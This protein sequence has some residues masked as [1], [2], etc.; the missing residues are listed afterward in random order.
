MPPRRH[1]HPWAQLHVTPGLRKKVLASKNVRIWFKIQ[2]LVK[3]TL[4]LGFLLIS[5]G[6]GVSNTPLFSAAV[7]TAEV[8]AGGLASRH[9]WGEGQDSR[10]LV[11]GSAKPG[12]A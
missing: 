8:A 6:F 11:S 5:A 9:P 3:L 4:R 1:S 10:T 7:A 12:S 2:R